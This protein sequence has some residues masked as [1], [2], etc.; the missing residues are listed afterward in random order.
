MTSANALRLPGHGLELK[1]RH[2]E[3]IDESKFITSG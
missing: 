2:T 3:T 1:W